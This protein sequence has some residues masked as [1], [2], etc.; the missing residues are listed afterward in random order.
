MMR[1]TLLLACLFLFFKNKKEALA[2]QPVLTL[3]EAISMGLE[4][5]LR[6]AQSTSDYKKATRRH[7]KKV[8]C[9]NLTASIGSGVGYNNLKLKY[10]VSSTDVSLHLP[11]NFLDKYLSYKENSTKLDIKRCE[12]ALNEI[13]KLSEIASAYFKVVL[14]QKILETRRRA[15]E[16]SNEQ[17]HQIE[18]AYSAGQEPKSRYT[19][20]L[21]Q[22][23]NDLVTCYQQEDALAKARV[24]L[25]DLIGRSSAD[26]FAVM[27]EIAPNPQI[28]QHLETAKVDASSSLALA[29]YELSLANLNLSSLWYKLLPTVS[30]KI[31]YKL[32][33]ES[34]SWDKRIS[35]GASATFNLFEMINLN[36]E[37][38]CGNIEVDRLSR[39]AV[40]NDVQLRVQLETYVLL[41]KRQK[42]H[43]ALI[44]KN[45][46]LSM[47]NLRDMQKQ[48]EL[49][50]ISALDFKDAKRNVEIGEVS[51][52]KTLYQMKVYELKIISSTCWDVEE[53]LKFFE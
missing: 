25:C 28:E 34:L 43:L 32:N 48:Y 4:N 24:E 46:E 33:D 53:F 49:G 18:Q 10:T 3:R 19:N 29:K 17:K 27:P 47:Q 6:I 22:Y 12:L 30:L 36:D 9:P 41:Y 14:E 5:N 21:I 52:L 20:A 15:M 26:N 42:E 40:V 7:S 39:A 51:L 2:A 23:N 50:K 13:S 45:L 37:L 8:F 38:A 31:R 1:K 35:Y 16:V 11:L 44:Q